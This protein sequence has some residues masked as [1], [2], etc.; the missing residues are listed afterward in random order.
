MT[1]GID[2]CKGVGE[3]EMGHAWYGMGAYGTQKKQGPGAGEHTAYSTSH[4]NASQILENRT[5]PQ[6]ISAY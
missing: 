2:R 5:T 3:G 1:N 6:I 4:K